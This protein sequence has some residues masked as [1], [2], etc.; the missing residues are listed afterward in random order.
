[1]SGNTCY[2]CGTSGWVAE[3]P[4]CKRNKLLERQ[5]K[6]IEESNYQRE[7]D[8]RFQQDQF[9]EAQRIQA[10]TNAVLLDIEFAKLEEERKKTRIVLETT[11]TEQQAFEKGYTWD[12]AYS[13]PTKINGR[14]EENGRISFDITNL[15]DPVFLIEKLTNSY[16]QGM[17]ERLKKEIGQRFFVTK[18]YLLAHARRAGEQGLKYF[19]VEYIPPFLE[20]SRFAYVLEC[21]SSETYGENINQKTGEINI[22]INKLDQP[23]KD[24]DLN[25]AYFSGLERFIE[26]RLLEENREES[27][28][29]RAKKISDL[30]DSVKA[31]E[32]HKRNVKLLTW[33][34]HALNWCITVVVGY[35]TW[36]SYIKPL[37]NNIF[38]VVVFL[39]LPVTLVWL[40]FLI[41]IPSIISFRFVGKM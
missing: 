28:A 35:L 9:K 38:F 14:L 26:R 4:T 36:E 41:L 10:E 30:N 39:A 7:Q 1:M 29:L 22:T 21:K 40:M 32:R 16:R 12:F 6:E 18:N 37:W 13:T 34:I 5:T 15:E 27:K 2:T 23:F 20:K 11:I 19:C 24:N 17:E 8:F 31:T 25:K 3:C 33:G